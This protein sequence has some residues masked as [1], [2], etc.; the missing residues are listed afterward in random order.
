MAVLNQAEREALRERGRFRL[1][2]GSMRAGGFDI[3]AARLEREF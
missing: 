3:E 2:L 1:D